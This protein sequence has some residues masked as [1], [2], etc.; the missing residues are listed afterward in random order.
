MKIVLRWPQCNAVHGAGPRP[1]VLDTNMVLDLLVFDDPAIAPVRA[2]LAEGA[3]HWIADA[4]QRVELERVL[5]Y[6]QIAPRVAFYGLSTASVLAAF[7]A[8]VAYQSEAPA[9]RVICKD[10]DDQHFLALAVQHQALLLS[11][12]K[13]VLVQRKRLALLGATVG[14]LLLWPPAAAAVPAPVGSAQGLAA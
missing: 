13:A 9:I 2:L 8:G 14:N 10:P 3:L 6:P 4:A 11:K 1:L 5:A 7:D 12:D